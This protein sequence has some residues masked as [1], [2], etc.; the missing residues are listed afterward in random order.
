MRMENPRASASFADSSSDAT[1]C[2]SDIQP[3]NKHS[4]NRATPAVYKVNG[5]LELLCGG[6]RLLER[7]H[8]GDV[9]IRLAVAL[10]VLNHDLAFDADDVVEVEFTADLNL[11][12]VE[13]FAQRGLGMERLGDAHTAIDCLAFFVLLV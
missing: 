6:G 7:Q 8:A 12:R 3:P 1:T 10:F 11:Q 4:R 5:V 2:G 13:H 9:G